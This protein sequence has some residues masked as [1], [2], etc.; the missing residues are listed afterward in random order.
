[1]ARD[2][3]LYR[4]HGDGKVDRAGFAAIGENVIIEPGVLVF[5]AENIRLGNN[6]YLGHQS[7]LKGYHRNSLDIGDNSWIGQQC[8][9]HSA[10]GVRIGR[11]VGIGPG[12]KI[13]SSYH[14]DEGIQI[15]ILLSEIEF[16]AV[17]VEDDC[18]IGVGA[19]LLPGVCIGRGVQVGAGAVVTEDVEDYAVV[20]GVPAR[21]I[22]IRDRARP[23]TRV[24]K[25]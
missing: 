24:S 7:I 11:N 18:D 17:V 2:I 23:S 3:G 12:V 16:A 20:A 22:R 25:K 5:H 6:V 21:P 8:F 15:P 14:I 9:I 4:S 1:M 10:G 13:L 19:I